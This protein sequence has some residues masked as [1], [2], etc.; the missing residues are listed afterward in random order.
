MTT[1]LEIGGGETV[2]FWI[3]APISV[4]AAMGLLFARKSVHAALCMI[5]VM[6][7]AG[8]FYIVNE[9]P[10]LGIVQIVV[11]SGAVMMLFLFV[12][13][14]VGVDASDSLVETIRGQ[15]VATVLVTLGLLALLGGAVGQVAWGEAVGLTA[16]NTETGNVTG[17]AYL[18]FGRYLWIFEVSALLLITAS[19]AAMVLAHRTRLAAAPNQRA[20]SDRR[21]REG[22]NLTGLPVPGVYARHNAVDTPALLPDGT[23]SELS[24]SRVLAARSQIGSPERYA[25]PERDRDHEIEEGTE[26]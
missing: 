8:V 2:L 1:P 25:G 10:F 3:L 12:V 21:F 4:I 26:R 13:M 19:V 22:K 24:V 18:I 9:A 23:P 6:L 14:L 7:I 15:R 11:Y 17:L 16:S 20:W 5:L